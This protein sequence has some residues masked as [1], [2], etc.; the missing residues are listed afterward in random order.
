M[1]Q[2]GLQESS[3]VEA[4]GTWFR[5]PNWVGN[6]LW[7]SLAGLTSS[8]FVGLIGLLGF[9]AELL[10]KR[11]GRPDTP[12]PDIDSSRIGDYFT[13]GIW[14]FLVY[15][16]VQLVGG[17]FVVLPVGG[18]F[19]LIVL[20][21]G[22]TDSEALTGLALA[23]GGLV[24]TLISL[25][26]YVVASPLIIRSMICQD[27][28]KAFDVAWAMDFFGKMKFE[29]LWSGLKFAVLSLA[30]ELVGMMLFCIGSIPA[31]GIILGGMVH[32]SA[33]WYEIYLNRGGIP[34]EPATQSSFH[35]ES[36]ESEVVDAE[37]LD[38]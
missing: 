37:V 29:L 3:V 19:L 5:S 13:K 33:Q 27:F 22:E 32:L 31:Q 25:L 10:E 1:E 9:G 38:D 11:A 6:L 17:I 21:S 12:T 7:L 34:V 8:V 30:V 26:F 35:S 14:P 16:A 15:L 4:M 36:V 20:A 23:A 2:S 28:A 18:M 24:T